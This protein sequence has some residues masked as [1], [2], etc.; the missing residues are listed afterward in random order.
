MRYFTSDHH[1]WHANILKY[2]PNREYKSVEEMNEDLINK[3]NHL[4][5][6]EDEVYY[7]GDFSLNSRA[8]KI[9]ER[10]NGKVYLIPGN[11]DK[12]HST[13]HKMK[14]QKLTSSFQL[15]TDHGFIILPEI[16]RTVINAPSGEKISTLLCHLPYAEEP[17]GEYTP[18]FMNIRPTPVAGDQLLLHGHVHQHWRTKL[19]IENGLQIPMVNVGVDVWG[20]FPVPESAIGAF[21]STLLDQINPIRRENF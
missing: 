19:Q 16:L 17:N 5:K 3:W 12:C 14:Q 2:C 8:L 20:G 15:Y 10:L 13:V 9:R 7:L 18:R 11:H 21:A 6:P 1:F 4:V